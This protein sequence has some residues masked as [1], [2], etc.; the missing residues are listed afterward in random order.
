MK[1]VKQDLKQE[2]QELNKENQTHN[3]LF[4]LFAH[5]KSVHE[6]KKHKCHQ[7]GKDFSSKWNLYKHVETI[8]EKRKYPCLIC[9]AKLSSKFILISHMKKK[10]EKIQDAHAK[11]ESNA[12]ISLGEQNKLQSNVVRRHI[13]LEDLK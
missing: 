11:L 3:S 6:G 12:K 7:C 8:H 9:N 2:I 1:Q 4:G 5:S 10:H 13:T